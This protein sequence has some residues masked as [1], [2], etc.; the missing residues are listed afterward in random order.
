MERVAH[1][2]VPRDGQR[3]RA[4]P[5]EALLRLGEHSLGPHVAQELRAERAQLLGDHGA[6]AAAC[7]VYL[8]IKNR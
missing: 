2:V 5:L 8:S 1:E 4:P 6:R 3:G 7:T